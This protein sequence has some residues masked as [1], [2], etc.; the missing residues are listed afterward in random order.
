MQ[1]E[2]SRSIVTSSH[3]EELAQASQGSQ[4]KGSK[5]APADQLIKE[6]SL[7]ATHQAALVAQLQARY[8]SERSSAAQKDGEVARLK[9]LLAE[10]QDEVASTSTYARN[11]TDEKMSLLFKVGKE[12][13]EFEDYKS[14]CL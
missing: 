5:D 6:L 13:A 8:A 2:K 12:R 4:P 14:S 7:V 1:T 11:L 10:A 9:Q 3:T